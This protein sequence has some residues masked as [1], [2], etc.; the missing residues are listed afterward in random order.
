MYEDG[1]VGGIPFTLSDAETPATSLTVQVSS[2]NPAL[3]TGGGLSLGGTGAN[4]TLAVTPLG[5]QS[6]V[7]M[8]TL[9]VMD[10]SGNTSSNTFLLTVVPVN[11]APTLNP[12]GNLGILTNAGQQTVSLS[13]ISSGAA[14]ENQALTIQATSSNPALIPDP[15]ISYFSPGSSAVLRFTPAANA[16]GVAVISVRVT[17]DGGTGNGGVNSITRTFTVTVSG[18]GGT[19]P[20]LQ[21]DRAGGNVVLSW[22]TASGSTW[23]LQQNT[24]I[25]N[26]NGWSAVGIAPN[27]VSGRYT[28]SLAAASAARFYRLCDGCP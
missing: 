18:S 10:G 3:V 16:T 1:T 12:L 17:D 25:T 13:G 27:I 9:T 2:S 7:S 24:T 23:V 4:R 19:S 5:N 20:Q 8:L 11:D 15:S 26:R 21:I 22:P 6:G 28:V 14:N